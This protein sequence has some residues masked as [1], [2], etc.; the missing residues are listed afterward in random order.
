[1]RL[2]PLDTTKMVSTI[3]GVRKAKVVFILC[4]VIC[5]IQRFNLFVVKKRSRMR[6]NIKYKL[7]DSVLS[8][9][10]CRACDAIIK[11]NA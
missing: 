1:M 2:F 7:I 5:I 8:T 9:K 3:H 6:E 11:E 10:Q 4:A